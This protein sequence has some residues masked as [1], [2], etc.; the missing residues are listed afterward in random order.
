MNPSHVIRFMLWM[1]LR[2][3][4][5]LTYLQVLLINASSGDKTFRTNALLGSNSDS[6]LISKTADKLNLFSGER[7]LTIK[8]ALSTKLKIKSKW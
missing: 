6:V 3:K 1:D 8:N 2:F 4:N 5:N 7:S